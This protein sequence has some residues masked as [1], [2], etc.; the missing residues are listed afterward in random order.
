MVL[1]CQSRDGLRSRVAY[2]CTSSPPLACHS[3]TKLLA[4]SS[5][6]GFTPIRIPPA[7]IPRSYSS[8]R[9]S[10]MPHFVSAP[11]KAP[12]RPTAPAAVSATAMGPA[13]KTP[14][15]GTS[16]SAPTP[17][18][19]GAIVPIVPPA[20]PPNLSADFPSSPSFVALLLRAVLVS[21]PGEKYR[22]RVSSDMSTSMSEFS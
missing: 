11:I 14:K 10:G 18:S 17:A 6:R 21:C 15:T 3:R 19:A 1:A 13:A 2:E 4:S 9:R 16:K 20:G 12:A 8:M 22:L 7:R 5:E